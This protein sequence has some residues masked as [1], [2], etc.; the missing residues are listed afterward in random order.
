M[1]EILRFADRQQLAEGLA[2][3]V[4]GDL[5]AA[6]AA[7]GA[8][9]L[10]VPGGTTPGAF[11]TALAGQPLD[12][13][14]IAVTLTDERWVPP[15]HPRSN[16]R[17]LR[18]A[19]LERGAEKAQFV[20]LYAEAATPE[21]AVAAVGAAVAERMLPLDVCVL[22]MGADMHIA[23][24]FPGADRLAEALDP[25]CPSPVLPIRAPGAGEE[26]ITLTLPS[27]LSAG[28]IYI[29]IAGEEKLAALDA[30]AGDGRVEEGPVR[31]VLRANRPVAVYYA[32]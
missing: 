5:A 20:P 22:G 12:W 8:T 21:A 6:L 9:T 26:R 32:P 29:L 10:A 4:A 17:L 11:L 19:L 16:A 23:S 15:D 1:A 3:R 30:A 14:R 2:A 27:L 31:A 25:G 13:A 18:A 7:R 28:H 24:L